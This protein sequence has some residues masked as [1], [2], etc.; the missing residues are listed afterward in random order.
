MIEA[1]WVGLAPH[2]LMLL[3]FGPD[4]RLAV[5]ATSREEMIAEAPEELTHAR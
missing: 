4:R 5:E 2:S 1:G 3:R